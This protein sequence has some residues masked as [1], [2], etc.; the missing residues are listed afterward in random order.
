MTLVLSSYQFQLSARKV[1]QW[2]VVL[3]RINKYSA[4]RN[5]FHFPLRG[6]GGGGGGGV[7]DTS[8]YIKIYTWRILMSVCELSYT[9]RVKIW[10]RSDAIYYTS[11]LELLYWHTSWRR[12]FSINLLFPVSIAIGVRHLFKTKCFKMIAIVGAFL[13]TIN[14]CLSCALTWSNIL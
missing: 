13:L 14:Q 1:I 12:I 9:E 8:I 10:Y 11:Y 2:C 4:V 6:W 5:S 7:A 3:C